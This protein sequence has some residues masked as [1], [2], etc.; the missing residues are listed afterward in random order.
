MGT[1]TTRLAKWT[2]VGAAKIIQNPGMQRAARIVT[3]QGQPIIAEYKREL[4]ADYGEEDGEKIW[5]TI[6]TL[7]DMYDPEKDGPIDEEE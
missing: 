3:M 2:A 6:N 7:S 1:P 5:A 4:V